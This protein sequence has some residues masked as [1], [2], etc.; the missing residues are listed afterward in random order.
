MNS[1]G[2]AVYD[3][4]VSRCFGICK[5]QQVES[6]AEKADSMRGVVATA[7]FRR[8]GVRNYAGTPRHS[9]AATPS[10]R[11]AL[12]CLMRIVVLT[13]LKFSDGFLLRQH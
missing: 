6:S 13:R 11:R 12:I 4:N 8:V 1:S 2:Q 7:L 5:S 10:M 9:E 3:V